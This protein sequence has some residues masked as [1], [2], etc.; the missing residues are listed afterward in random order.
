M[1]AVERNE[2]NGGGLGWSFLVVELT[3]NIEEVKET[4]Q[5]LVHGYELDR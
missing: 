5:K 2:F 3:N 1:A 4:A